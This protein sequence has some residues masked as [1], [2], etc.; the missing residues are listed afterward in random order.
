[1]LELTH[2]PTARAIWET[3]DRQLTDSAVWVPTV[4]YPE[5]ELTS[6]RLHNYQYNPIWG[7]LADQSWVR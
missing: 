5:I 3:V 4:T 2:P 1:M 7:F 6:R